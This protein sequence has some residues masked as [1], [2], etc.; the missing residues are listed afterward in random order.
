MSYGH[1]GGMYM[2][3]R[4][5]CLD[6]LTLSNVFLNVCVCFATCIALPSAKADDA[7]R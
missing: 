1:I 2:L 5:E 4:Q 6:F 3:Q 7:C